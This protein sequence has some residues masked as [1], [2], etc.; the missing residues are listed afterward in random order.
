M[1]QIN[2]IN[3]QCIKTGTEKLYK[4]CA[5]LNQELEEKANL[6][7]NQFKVFQ[8]DFT[9]EAARLNES[10]RSLKDEKSN[11][12]IELKFEREANN[13]NV[14]QSSDSNSISDKFGTRKE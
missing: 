4:G 2:C 3:N 13:S 9:D 14:Q 11:L 12:D 5:N 8:Q 1:H 7:Q 10:I 6:F